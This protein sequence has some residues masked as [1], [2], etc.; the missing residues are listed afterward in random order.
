MDTDARSLAIAE[1]VIALGKKLGMAVIG[2]G[3]ESL[4]RLNTLIRIGCDYGQG[5]FI[6]K[7]IR[8]DYL[9]EWYYQANYR[10]LFA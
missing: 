2:E 3:I 1:T 7:P 5:Y 9:V 10:H 6:S 4:T 8:P